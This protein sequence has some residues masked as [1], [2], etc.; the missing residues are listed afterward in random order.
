MSSE[1]DVYVHT[2]G[3]IDES[4]DETADANTGETVGGREVVHPDTADREF[5]WRGWILVGVLFVAFV[6]APLLVYF[7][8]PALP[9]YVTLIIVPLLPAFLL[10]AVAV[11]ATTR[12]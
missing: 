12:P 2:P 11:W 1:E 9:W 4:E 3:A 10:G 6:G 7:R 5:D 8:P